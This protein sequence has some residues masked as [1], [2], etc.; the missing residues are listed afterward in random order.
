M[1]RGPD[2]AAKDVAKLRARSEAHEHT[3]NSTNYANPSS[4]CEL[5]EGEE[6]H[7]AKVLG[8]DAIPN[9]G[10]DEN[11]GENCWWK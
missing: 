3:N 2:E 11:T 10:P 9:A 5:A 6:T 8:D 1:P 7:M 4:C